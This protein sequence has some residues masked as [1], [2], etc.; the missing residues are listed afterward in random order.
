L[1]T[2]AQAEILEAIKWQQK[3]A[4]NEMLSDGNPER[5]RTVTEAVDLPPA[6]VVAGKIKPRLPNAPAVLVAYSG[7]KDS[8]A[9]IDLCIRGGKRVEAFFMH[10]LPGL[11][12]SEFWCD[13]ARRTFGI[14]VRQYQ[15]WNTCYFLRRGVFRAPV[16]VPVIKINDIEAAAREDSGL[17]W[18]GYGLKSIDS[19]QRRG[20]MN[21][22]ADG[23]C[24]ERQLFTPIK[25]WNNTEVLAYLSR[26]RIQIPSFAGKRSTGI[27][28][29]PE[30]L[31]HFRTN[32]PEDY[33]RILRVFPH[34]EGQADRIRAAKDSTSTV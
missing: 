29:T 10:F 7:G 17:E 22:W 16:D 15:H 20:R 32:W 27:D 6:E 12:Y 33:H 5:S 26:R 21:G 30:T 14:T 3:A 2:R 31:Y 19:L 4:G 11:D 9:T 28:L 25:N 24:P 1:K 13:Y 23:I 18:I 8:L 34:A